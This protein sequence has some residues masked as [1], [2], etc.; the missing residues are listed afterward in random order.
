ML[1]SIKQNLA[2]LTAWLVAF[3]PAG[4]FL[5][6]LLDSAFVPLPGGADAVMVLLS[7]NATLGWVIVCAL[8][9]TLG[10]VLGCLV[11]YHVSRRAGAGALRRFSPERQAQVSGLIDR[12]DVLAVLVASLLPPPFPFK[13]FIVSAGVFRMNRLRFAAGVAAGRLFRFLLEGYLAMRY[14]D[15]ATRLL[16]RHY[17]KIGLALALILVVGVVGKN[18]IDRRRRV[19][20]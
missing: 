6:A 8:T 3:G 9:G 1:R 14:G 10:S 5:I 7:L 20:A 13:L 16:A 17:P 18:L 4:L 12:Y 15:E 19:T 11:L 2:A